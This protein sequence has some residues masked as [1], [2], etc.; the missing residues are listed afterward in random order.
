MPLLSTIVKGCIGCCYINCAKFYRSPVQLKV[1][2]RIHV[3]GTPGSPLV[4]LRTQESL[5]CI[6]SFAAQDL[7]KSPFSS[8]LPNSLKN[9][10]PGESKDPLEL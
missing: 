2:F 4:Q 7:A 8:S 1:G 6:L 5:G 10:L 9:L 3:K